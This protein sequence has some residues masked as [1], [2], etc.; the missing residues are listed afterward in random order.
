MMK[1][2]RLLRLIK[3]A[4]VLRASQVFQRWETSIRINYNSLRFWFAFVFF[5]LAAHWMA[6]ICV[7]FGMQADNSEDSWLTH[8]VPAAGDMPQTGIVIYITSL[9]WSSMTVTS[10][11]YG[12]VL[13]VTLNERIAC[14]CL[15]FASSLL[16]AWALG[17]ILSSIG[18][19]DLGQA[20]FRQ[21]LDDLNH[22]M[23]DHRLPH[24]MQ[25]RLRDFFFQTK[26]IQRVRSY[27]DVV[28]Q[29]SPSL[30]GEVAL[31]ANQVWIRK[32][33]YFDA[34]FE[35]LPGAF[36]AAFAK[37]LHVDVYAQGDVFGEPWT[38]YILHRGLCVRSMR[39]CR[40]GS[41]WGEDFILTT[42]ELLN[43]AS[44]L[45][46]T[47]VEVASV[48]RNK[49]D[50]LLERMP[51]VQKIIRRAVV[52]IA[53]NRSILREANQRAEALGIRKPS[54]QCMMF[55]SLYK[56]AITAETAASFRNVTKASG[57]DAD[58]CTSEMKARA[59]EQSEMQCKL[60]TINT[61]MLVM[62]AHME[63]NFSKLGAQLATLMH[64][65][66]ELMRW[67]EEHSLKNGGSNT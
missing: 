21:M 4:R 62:Q 57:G 48:S 41:V 7:M 42:S 67:Q 61:E 54:T 19:T 52:R 45:A 11:G 43:T 53:V 6:C 8:A 60:D 18:S 38:L 25:R 5:L 31:I 64:G 22:M 56:A 26:D 28:D 66:E 29:L 46:L 37:T 3:L 35:K 63:E 49:L 10:V 17:E 30:K 44:V 34:N 55:S 13:P 36:M 1:V 32:I 12:D 50:P 47:F 58:E 40:S 59:K 23:A 51:E 14:T 33:W 27:Y 24:V 65:Q 2:V 15:M 9:Y 39:F 16:Y 20:R